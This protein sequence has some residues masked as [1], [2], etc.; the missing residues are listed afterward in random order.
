MTKVNSESIIFLKTFYSKLSD[1]KSIIF[2]YLLVSEFE[3]FL[4][5]S[6]SNTIKN[7][8]DYELKGLKRIHVQRVNSSVDL[9]KNDYELIKIAFRLNSI[10]SKRS[11]T[12]GYG[13]YSERKIANNEKLSDFITI[14]KDYIEKLENSSEN[15]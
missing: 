4:F 1:D 3:R 2:D 11:I 8:Y 13:N 12:M 10:L 5:L 14:L 15:F 9:D 7:K 6:V